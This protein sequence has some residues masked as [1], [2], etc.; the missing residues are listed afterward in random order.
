LC[1]SSI[2]VSLSHKGG[3]AVKSARAPHTA[4]QFL[5]QRAKCAYICADDRGKSDVKADLAEGLK[6]R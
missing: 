6:G 3:G 2:R 1:D 4:A 5:I